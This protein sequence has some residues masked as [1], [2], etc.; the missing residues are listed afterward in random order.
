VRLQFRDAAAKGFDVRGIH[1]IDVVRD[2]LKSMNFPLLVR[3]RLTPEEGRTE[4][5]VQWGTKLYAYSV[6]AHIDKILGGL[7]L[8]SNAENAPVA[9]VVSRHIFEWTAHACYMSTKL[10][11]CYQ[12]KDWEEAWAVLTPPAIGNLWA[13]KHGAKYA[14]ESAQP[15]PTAP[16]PIRIGIAV[17]AYEA[18]QLQRHGWQEAKDTYGLLSEFSHPNAACLQQYQDFGNDGST[19][20]GYVEEG[21]G[22]DS[23]LPFVNCCLI[24]LMIFV[25]A[26]LQL[27]ADTAVRPGILKIQDELAKLA[28]K[29]RRQTA[30]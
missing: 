9:K 10:T 5:L 1:P 24:D 19:A 18:Y 22:A 30:P 3:P 16:D 12:R 13:K 14:L 8:L 2:G 28:P 23:P 17:S 15:L 7:A 27:A 11:D 25:D 21:N 26:L 29:I 4:E 20:I 6:V